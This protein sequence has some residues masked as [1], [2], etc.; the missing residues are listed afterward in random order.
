MNSFFSIN[1]LKEIGFNKIGNNVLISKKAS[2]YS[3]EK[4]T[5]GNNVRIDDFCIL[6]GNIE[7]KNYVH[8]ACY[9]CLFSGDEI[10]SIG[11]Y[12]TL[13]SKVSV[14]SKT[15]DYSGNFMTNPMIPEKYTNVINKK[16][17]IGDYVIVG[18]GSVILPG[19]TIDEGVA[20]GALT[21]INKNLDPWGIYVGIPAKRLKDRSKELLQLKNCFIE[22]M[23]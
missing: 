5:L 16:V 12:S 9:T 8:I 18:S 3:P 1:E 17:I 13:S 10:I 22:E 2:I 7:I 6:S 23:K 11:N 19:V 4:I 21:L 15:D 20:C 14:Y